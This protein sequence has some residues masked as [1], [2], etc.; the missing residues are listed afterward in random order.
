MTRSDR[1]HA[2][3][4]SDFDFRA[5]AEPSAHFKDPTGGEY[6]A[7]NPFADEL[8]LLERLGI[9][10]EICTK[11]DCYWKRDGDVYFLQVESALTVRREVRQRGERESDERV[12]LPCLSKVERSEG[13]RGSDDVRI[14]R[15]THGAVDRVLLT[16]A[17]ENLLG[18]AVQR[19]DP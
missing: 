9:S 16:G 8:E 11:V 5:R 3:R 19:L 10:P 2:A 14:H 12:K 17:Q 13:G 7:V 4:L 18:F 1:D 6:V 15:G